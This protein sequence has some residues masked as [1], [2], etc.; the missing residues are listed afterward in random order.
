MVDIGRKDRVGQPQI[1]EERNPRG[2][3]AQPDPSPQP[4]STGGHAST[5]RVNSARPSREQDAKFVAETFDVPQRLAAR[6]VAGAGA[7]ESEVV[8]IA[9]NVERQRR[10]GEYEGIPTPESDSEDFVADADETALKPVLRRSNK[11]PG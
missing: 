8:S 6:L 1:P 5:S 4:I 3:D 11:R 9:A 7:P 10:R 2:H